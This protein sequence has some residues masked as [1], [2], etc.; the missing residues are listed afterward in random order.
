[1]RLGVEMFVSAAIFIG[2]F[3]LFM[4]VVHS[5]Y[6]E[7]SPLFVL[8][9]G[10]M[11]QRCSLAERSGVPTGLV[12][13]SPYARPVALSDAGGGDATRIRIRTRSCRRCLL[14]KSSGARAM[15]SRIT[16]FGLATEFLEL[17]FVESTSGLDCCGRDHNGRLFRWLPNRASQSRQ[18]F[19]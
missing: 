4:N 1:M 12:S 17:G 2:S 13:H 18:P 7:F 19:S 11:V 16:L 10:H 8:D 6:G 9:R 3:V 5:Y 15:A 14:L